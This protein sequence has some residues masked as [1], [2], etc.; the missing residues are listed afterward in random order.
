MKS[1]LLVLIILFF[2]SYNRNAQ[3]KSNAML[4]EAKKAIEEVMRFIFRLS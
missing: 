3:S 4:E 1:I 2:L